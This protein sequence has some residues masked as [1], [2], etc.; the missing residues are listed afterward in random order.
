MQLLSIFAGHLDPRVRVFLNVRIV[1]I[2]ALLCGGRLRA[3]DER[4]PA[5]DADDRLQ[6]IQR[7]A[8]LGAPLPGRFR[9]L[10]ASDDCGGAA[11]SIW[12]SVDASG[13]LVALDENVC[14]SPGDRR[15]R[16]AIARPGKPGL[17]I[18][19]DVDLIDGPRGCY[20]DARIA[21]RF[22]A[23]REGR[24]AVVVFDRIRHTPLYRRLFPSI[25]SF[26][27]QADG[28]LVVAYHRRSPTR[29]G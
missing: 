3:P 24:D 8:V 1:A 21:G 13:S 23:W 22:V 12:P 10:A 4:L 6:L 26:D 7:R 19:C 25:E 17:T 11:I 15:R 20:G 29:A 9:L 28:K 16:I 27:V 5:G 18:L 2:T 14:L